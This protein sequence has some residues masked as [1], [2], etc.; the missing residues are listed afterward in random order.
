MKKIIFLTSI[1]LILFTV[2]CAKKEGTVYETAVSRGNLVIGLDAT[3]AP[4]G[5]KEEN[6]EIVGFDI[7]LAKAVGEYLKL[8]VISQPI[9][10]DTKEFELKSK[11]IDMIWNGLTI[12]ESRKENML[13]S[14]SYMNNSQI[15]ITNRESVKTVN[16]LKNLK[17]GIQT[18]SSAEFAV[19]DSNIANDIQL[20]KF[21][22]YATALYELQNNLI[23]AIVVDDIVGRYMLTVKNI[24]N[25]FILD[26]DF[27]S[28]EYGIGFNLGEIKLK[29]KID[30]AL[31]YLLES[32]V[33]AEISNKW[34][35][36]NLFILGE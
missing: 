28:E 17:V 22:D 9:N 35:G 32:G 7:D 1:M 4:M 16:D 27:G 11:Q 12:T 30:E 18:N 21:D 19:K 25:L 8:E 26:E 14:K 15:V 31:T 10:W 24:T 23:D 20:L 13:F 2:A 36:N 5:F 3:F 33:A 34:F 6:G 29:E